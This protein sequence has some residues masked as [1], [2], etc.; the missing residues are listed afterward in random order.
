MILA[1]L[2]G[3]SERVDSSPPYDSPD[4]GAGGEGGGEGGGGGRV[5]CSSTTSPRLMLCFVK[6]NIEFV[7]LQ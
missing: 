3:D 6:R 7:L 1:V 2:H 4:Q 5:S